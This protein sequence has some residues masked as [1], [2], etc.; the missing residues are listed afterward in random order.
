MNSICGTENRYASFR[1]IFNENLDSLLTYRVPDTF[2]FLYEN[3]ELSKHSLGQRASAIILFL[4]SLEEYDLIMIDQP[5]DDLDNQTVYENVIK[6]LCELKDKTQFIFVTHN[7]N[8]PVLGE[9]EQIITCFLNQDAVSHDLI[10]KLDIGSLD[11]LAI[12]DKIIKIMEGGEEAF[13]KREKIYKIW[14]HL[15]Y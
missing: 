7:P 14:N 3:K 13:Q 15:T 10:F 8:I 2:K 11:S 12:Q 6:E 4:L 1:K 9:A 5:E